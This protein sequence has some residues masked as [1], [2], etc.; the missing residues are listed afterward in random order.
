MLPTNTRQ[1]LK[2]IDDFNMPQ[3]EQQS[4]ELVDLITSHKER[5]LFSNTL[6]PDT[7]RIS[8][9]WQLNLTVVLKLAKINHVNSIEF[10]LN[11]REHSILERVII[12]TVVLQTSI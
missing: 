10:Y 4:A 7:R 3:N 6:M 1:W 8:I 5:C 12:I 2:F 11:S 9:I